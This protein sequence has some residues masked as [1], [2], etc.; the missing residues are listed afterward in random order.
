M[1]FNYSNAAKSL[2]KKIEKKSALAAPSQAVSTDQPVNDGG[3]F[4]SRATSAT[5]QALLG[6]GKF[7]GQATKDVLLG[8]DI[9]VFGKKLS[10]P[11]VFT[12]GSNTGL[13]RSV[14]NTREGQNL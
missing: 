9:D 12:R 8:A 1:A 14:L 7:A 2:G 11:G 5:G 13:I 10:V 4:L 6:F 3:S